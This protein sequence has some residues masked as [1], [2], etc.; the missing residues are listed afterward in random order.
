ME[1]IGDEDP[2]PTGVNREIQELGRKRNGGYGL[3]FTEVVEAETHV[4][5]GIKYDLKSSAA[6]PTGS[7]KICEAVV[8]VVKSWLHSK[9][10]LHFLP[11]PTTK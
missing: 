1:R 7:P 9:Q 10:L 3:K 6:T 2:L 5:S 4:V 11:S 8:V